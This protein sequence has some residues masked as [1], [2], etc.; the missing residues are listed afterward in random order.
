MRKSDDSADQD[1]DTAFTVLERTEDL[2]LLEARPSTGRFH[3]IRRHLLHAGFPIVGDFR[4]AGEE[5]SYR[6]GEKLGT[7]ERMM[8]QARRLGLDH[9]VTGERVT[10][11]APVDPLD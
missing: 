6:M 3:Q 11:S 5:R 1:A 9:P 8:L 4:Y 2:S 7:G 10:I